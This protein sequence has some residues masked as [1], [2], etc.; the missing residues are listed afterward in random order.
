MQ[1]PRRPHSLAALGLAAALLAGCG[2]SGDSDETGTPGGES[3][4]DAATG[5]GGQ[6][7]ESPS[8]S[9]SDG[10]ESPSGEPWADPDPSLPTVSL[11][12]PDGWDDITEFVTTAPPEGS[13]VE[14]YGSP[15]D[16]YA[17]SAIVVSIPASFVEGRPYLQMVEE[18]GGSGAEYT[19][20]APQAVAG[21]TI[22]PL[23]TQVDLGGVT[24]T[25]RVYPIPLLD[26]GLVEVTLTTPTDS[27]AET[28]P[29]WAEILASIALS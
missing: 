18:E 9:G 27:L 29:V 20:T 11:T 17:S 23:E 1:T 22:V 26:G 12:V 19:E 21:V 5:S 16:E 25:Q 2:G 6:G 15:D 8:E 24:G 3:A 28:E 13:A 14:A 7:A 10:A 4:T